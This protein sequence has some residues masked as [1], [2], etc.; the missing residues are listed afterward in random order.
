MAKRKRHLKIYQKGKRKSKKKLFLVLKIIGG[1]FL[2]SILFSLFLFLYYAKDLPRPE[3]FLEREIFQST[4]IYDSTGE[5]LLY[6]IYGEEK[7][8]IVSL[9]KVPDHL[10]NAVITAEDA[11][12]YKHFG[13]DIRGIIRSILVNLK[14]WRPAQGGSTIPQQLI[15]SSFL[16]LEKTAERKIREIILTLELDRRYSKDQILEW[17]LNQVPFGPNLYGVEAVSK[18]YFGKSVSDISLPEAALLASLIRAP[19]YY[20]P[21]GEHLDE[22]LAR[23][24]YILE[25]MANLD[26]ITQEEKEA[27]QQEEIKFADFLSNIS[28]PHFVLYVKEYLEERY[29]ED[30][31]KEKGLRVYTSLDWELQQSAEKVIQE[32]MEINKDFKANNAALLAISPQD[33][34]ILAMVGS[35]DWFADSYPEG[36]IPGKDCLFEPHPNVTLRGRQ[37]GS[38]FKPFVYATAFKK[39]YNDTTKVLDEET[40]F[41]IWGDKEYTPQNYD[42]KFRGLVTLREGLAQSL[43]IPSIKVLYLIGSD[44]KIEALEIN[45]FRGEEK[46]FQEGLK[47]SIETAEKL[48]ITTLD[49]PISFYGPS[50]VLG[51]GEVNLLEMVSAYGVFANEGV[52]IEPVTIIRIEDSKGNIIEENRKDPK[53]VLESDVANLVTDILSDNEA[54]TPMFGPRSSLYFEGH[55]VAAKT[56]TTDNYRDA[57]TIG[58]T[59]SAV[60]GVWVGN[61]D[62]SPMEKLPAVSLAGPIFHEIMEET[63]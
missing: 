58:Y 55:K 47:E 13:I 22:L 30:F 38:A 36:C 6:E 18:S 48:G 53:R 19:S 45:D 60:V 54:R 52:R 4:K 15:R 12:F 57:W 3:K 43:N 10:K 2:F 20:A 34:H 37:P 8:E 9:E 32:R 21:Y 17:Y 1:F 5:H 49:Q 31:L 16:T 59:S 23:K 63:F 27:A 56:G 7:R 51:G 62:N 14:L 42:E 26:Y 50:I 61:N 11:N 33:G 24:D 40:N 28:A 29:G 25:R 35:R 46:T 39:D 44:E 41:G